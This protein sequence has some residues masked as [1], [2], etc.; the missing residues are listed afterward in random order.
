MGRTAKQSIAVFL[1]VAVLGLFIWH[2][3]PDNGEAR[4]RQRDSDLLRAVSYNRLADATR[5]LDEGADPN[6]RVPPLSL[7]Q[8][9]KLEYQEMSHGKRPVAW[10]Q[11]DAAYGDAGWSVLEVAVM[12]GKVSLVQALLSKGADVEY[13]DPWG[14]TALGWANM[15]KGGSPLAS[16]TADSLRIA[17]LLKAAEANKKAP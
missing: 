2:L 13:R 4:Q 12:H 3:W 11:I 8:K 15:L 9:T 5:L 14:Q 16:R 1:A 7:T 6:T 17:A 10:S